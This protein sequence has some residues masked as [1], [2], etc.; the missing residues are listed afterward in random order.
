MTALV[1][2]H[3][4][5]QN[6]H[7]KKP[8]TM[9]GLVLLGLRSQ[10]SSRRGSGHRERQQSNGTDTKFLHCRIPSTFPSALI[11]TKRRSIMLLQAF[12]LIPICSLS[13][14]HASQRLRISDATIRF[15]T[16]TRK[17]HYARSMVLLNLRSQQE[18]IS[19]YADK[20]IE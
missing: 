13:L 14:T 9:P 6:R 8:R 11:D 19:L 4:P 5:S 12:C 15:S 16:L 3:D 7:T 1:G 17:R 20:V 10:I 2:H 18:T